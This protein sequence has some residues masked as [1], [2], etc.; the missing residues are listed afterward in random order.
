MAGAGINKIG[1][2]DV[3]FL[4]S[5]NRNVQSKLQIKTYFADTQKFT[6]GDPM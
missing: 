1:I 6:T 3:P 4:K 5:R 2:T